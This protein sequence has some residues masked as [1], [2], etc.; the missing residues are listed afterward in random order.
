M[1][2]REALP[3]MALY[4]SLVLVVPGPTNTLLL[5][6]GLK[7][8]LRRTLPLVVAEAMGY[9]VAIS[10][11][12]FFL[13]ALAASRPWLMDTVKLL[14]SAYI[15]WLAIKMWR[16]S[17]S[18]HNLAAG[19]VGFRDVF[20]ATL[21][22]PK[23]VL[24]ASTVFPIEAFRS[25]EYFMQAILVFLIVLAPIGIGWSCLGGLLTSRRSWSGYTSTFL[26]CASLVLV[27]FSGSLVYSILRP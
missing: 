25:G 1:S 26:R 5:S 24:F 3:T 10:A 14:S 11:W 22:N 19:P 18:L 12:G 16:K 21:M 9:V 4:L 20:V 13:F 17:R 27:M 6:S 23:A 2:V 7:V 15:L 8:G